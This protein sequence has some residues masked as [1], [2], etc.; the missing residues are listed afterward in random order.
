MP[1]EKWEN[2]SKGALEDLKEQIADE[3][4]RQEEGRRPDTAEEIIESTARR[5]IEDYFKA[6]NTGFSKRCIKAILRDMLNKVREAQQKPSSKRVIGEIEAR[7]MFYGKQLISQQESNNFS[8]TFTSWGAIEDAIGREL[9][10]E[11]RTSM[12]RQAELIEK[13]CK[14]MHEDYDKYVKGKV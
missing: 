13:A 6:G 3:K 1:E 5:L 10:N 7:A 14:A 9:S 4:K 2:M 12:K 11:Q 8:E